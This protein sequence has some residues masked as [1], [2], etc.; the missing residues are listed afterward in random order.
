MHPEL[1]AFPNRFTYRGDLINDPTCVKIRM[2]PI[3]HQ[4]LLSWMLSVVN[5][6]AKEMAR[7]SDNDIQMT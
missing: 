1:S 5:D 3:I 2:D 6:N 4:R 7:S